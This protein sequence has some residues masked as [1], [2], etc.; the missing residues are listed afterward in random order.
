MAN[1]ENASYTSAFV[2]VSV[3]GLILGV[4]LLNSALS[5]YIT[6]L[7][8]SVPINLVKV[9][10][11]KNLASSSIYV[12]Q[13][14]NVSD[15]NPDTYELFSSKDVSQNTAT[16]NVNLGNETIFT[17]STAET[18]KDLIDVFYLNVER[19]DL[20]DLLEPDFF[21][22]DTGLSKSNFSVKS[23]GVDVASLLSESKNNPILLEFL[24]VISQEGL[25]TLNCYDAFID[26]ITP[27]QNSLVAVLPSK[28][29]FRVNTKVQEKSLVLLNEERE[30]D[31]NSIQGQSVA[32]KKRINQP[33]LN[34]K[35][36]A[37]MATKT[38]Q[39]K[40]MP[41]K[42]IDYT[43]E[44]QSTLEVNNAVLFFKPK[45]KHW[46]LESKLKLYFLVI[47]SRLDYIRHNKVP[48]T[49]FIVALMMDA[50][51]T[52]KIKTRLVSTPDAL[53]FRLS[54]YFLSIAFL[55]VSFVCLGLYFSTRY[56]AHMLMLGFL[57]FGLALH[58][59]IKT[60]PF[61]RTHI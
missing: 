26:E 1:E 41:Y 60:L 14:L 38:I 35:R 21:Q 32:T 43:K 55:F 44:H 59:F 61:F 24:Q 30:G 33:S 13:K 2:L 27:K 23:L 6:A 7:P 16:D 39:L 3:V 17:R 10:P 28:F 18:E 36:N 48:L 34:S 42:V 29:D 49:A 12:Q 51:L 5:S 15:V 20:C 37:L 22:E 40:Q 4:H 45:N 19:N 54:L 31:T 50:F 11:Q 47:K 52:L 57:L 53:K 46:S 56:F 9:L 25:I 58:F 8:V